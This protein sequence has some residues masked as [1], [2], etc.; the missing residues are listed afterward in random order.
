VKQDPGKSPRSLAQLELEAK[1]KELVPTALHRNCLHLIPSQASRVMHRS[2]HPQHARDPSTQRL[3]GKRKK[4]F[5]WFSFLGEKCRGW[6][7]FY[8]SALLMLC[9]CFALPRFLMDERGVSQI[10]NEIVDVITVRYFVCGEVKCGGRGW[11]GDKLL[12]EGWKA[13]H[14]NMNS[15]F[16][17]FFP[18]LSSFPGLSDPFGHFLSIWMMIPFSCSIRYP[19]PFSLFHLFPPSPKTGSIPVAL[20]VGGRVTRF[21]RPGETRG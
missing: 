12:G 1:E 21:Q 14:A 20:R 7:L 3:L 18:F 2:V 8:F 15:A 4:P 6:I 19:V 16:F 11:R 13:A 9:C 10:L 17:F 5:L